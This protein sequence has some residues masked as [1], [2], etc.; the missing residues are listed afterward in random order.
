MYACQIPPKAYF[1]RI[2]GGGYDRTEYY[3]S[4]D[5]Y[6]SVFTEKIAPYLTTLIHGAG[7]APGYP[8]I[9]TNEATDKMIQ[10]AGGKQKMVTVQD[11]TCD[12]EVS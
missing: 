9:M 12:L 4:P 1:E 5:L 3:K 2:S 7:W 6:H 11:V 8:R 10:S